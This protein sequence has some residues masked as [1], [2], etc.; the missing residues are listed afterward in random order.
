LPKE[1]SLIFAHI[2]P[3]LLAH[4]DQTLLAQWDCEA[5]RGFRVVVT[6]GHVMV[7]CADGSGSVATAS[8]HRL[9]QERQWYSIK[10]AVDPASGSIEIDQRPIVPYARI[11]DHGRFSGVL[12]VSPAPVEAPPYMAGRP[13][14]GGHVASHFDGKI[15]GPISWA[16]RRRCSLTM[17]CAL[18]GSIRRCH[19]PS[20]RAGISLASSKERGRSTSDLTVIMGG[21][22]TCRRTA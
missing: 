15:D 9:M 13:H 3:T 19:H 18:A 7:I 12:A 20:W 4:D 11:A 17:R 10:V 1:H 21:C 6:G 5:D 16:A 2:W 22:S 8:A 14:A